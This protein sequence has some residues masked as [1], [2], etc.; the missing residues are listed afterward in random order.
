MGREVM[1]GLL[2]GIQQGAGAAEPVIE[3]YMD[4]FLE[5]R[6]DQVM[7]SEKGQ[8]GEAV[9]AAGAASTACQQQ[10]QAQAST[11]STHNQHAVTPEL[12]RR[13][14]TTLGTC[15][16]TFDGSLIWV[17]YVS[18]ITAPP[19]TTTWPTAAGSGGPAPA[20]ECCSCQPGSGELSHHCYCGL[21][22]G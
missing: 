18:S 1:T 2:K 13:L 17:C 19:L 7:T 6:R 22:S 4:N 10:Q 16:T 5:Y 12:W 8:V 3:Q 9:A 21:P 14:Q 15:V 11:P 20:P